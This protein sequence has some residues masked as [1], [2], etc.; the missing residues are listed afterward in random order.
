MRN[1]KDRAVVV[2][3]VVVVLVLSRR[4]GA[5]FVVAVG[6]AG[7]LQLPIDALLCLPGEG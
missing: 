7:K 6:L 5:S 2:V 1:V 4:Q 3:L